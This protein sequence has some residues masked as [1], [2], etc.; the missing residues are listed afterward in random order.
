MKRSVGRVKGVRSIDFDLNTGEGKVWFASGASVQP[1]LLWRAI[2]VAG[3]TP[4]QVETAG[5]TYSG[6]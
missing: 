5:K 6:P 4:V 1:A 2:K 3:F